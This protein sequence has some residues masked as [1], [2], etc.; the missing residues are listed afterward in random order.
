MGME[1]F[2]QPPAPEISGEEVESR[3]SPEKE[4]AKE[5]LLRMFNDL[6]VRDQLGVKELLKRLHCADVST[7]LKDALENTLA[8]RAHVKKE[9]GSDDDYL[10]GPIEVSDSGE[11]R[12]SDNRVDRLLWISQH[13]AGE[14]GE[15]LT[16]A[17]ASKVL[18]QRG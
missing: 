17:E 14:V 3:E 10:N 12:H 16:P 5:N 2:K 18:E 11:R 1:G 9:F 6:N 4:K 7:S 13:N 15:L 8:E